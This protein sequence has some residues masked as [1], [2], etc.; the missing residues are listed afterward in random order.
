MS[1]HIDQGYN[2]AI[3]PPSKG[4]IVK[5]ASNRAR[6]VLSG[7]DSLRK[8][9]RG[10]VLR[11][12][13]CSPGVL[14][15]SRP[16]AWSM[17]GLVTEATQVA[18]NMLMCLATPSHHHHHCTDPKPGSI[19]DPYVPSALE[20]PSTPSRKHLGFFLG[21]WSSFGCSVTHC[22]LIR[23]LSFSISHSVPVRRSHR[24]QIV[25]SLFLH[26]QPNPI[27]CVVVILVLPDPDLLVYIAVSTVLLLVEEIEE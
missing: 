20:P 7:D 5:S 1:R 8:V 14:R 13:S 4:N 15:P 21:P 2:E 3:L 12:S 10:Q 26:P 25:P 6:A 16:L 23:T 11:L 18:R 27:L 17:S 22:Y 9:N 24:T 19:I